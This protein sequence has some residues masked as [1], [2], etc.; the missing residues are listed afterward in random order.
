MYEA[1]HQRTVTGETNS[2]YGTNTKNVNFP[3]QST[4]DGAVVFY[5]CYD[6]NYNSV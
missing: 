5:F 2:P 1:L 6:N 3:T 4:M